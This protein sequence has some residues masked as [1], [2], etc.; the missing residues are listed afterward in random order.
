MALSHLGIR[1]M[2]AENKGC[3]AELA[4]AIAS[5][6]AGVWAK[7]LRKIADANLVACKLMTLKPP[8]NC[9]RKRAVDAEAADPKISN[10]C[11]CSGLIRALGLGFRVLGSRIRGGLMKLQL[12]T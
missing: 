1:A 9:D 2:V 8:G 4:F 6:A 3:M 5:Y 12:W 7:V 10:G 11:R